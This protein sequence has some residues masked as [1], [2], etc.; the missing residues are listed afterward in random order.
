MARSPS[1]SQTGRSRLRSAR[2]S[3]VPDRNSIGTVTRLR[4]SARSV[5]GWPAGWSGKAKNTRPRTC[6][7][8]DSAAAIEAIRPLMECPPTRSGRSL[9]A[10]WAA[11]AAART[12][13][14]STACE[15]RPPPPRSMYGNWYRKVAIPTSAR[16]AAIVSRVRCRIL[17]LAPCPST[18][19]QRAAAGRSSSADT[20][21]FSSVATNLVSTGDASFIG[22]LPFH[23][24]NSFT[25]ATA[26]GSAARSAR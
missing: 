11:A 24:T 18:S 8:G 17:V 20:S 25:P 9:A 23:S 4:C 2:S 19:S 14:R 26:T 5:A 21:P 3:R 10:A 7:R 15:S 13:A 1:R 12:V 22:Y 6:S 16:R